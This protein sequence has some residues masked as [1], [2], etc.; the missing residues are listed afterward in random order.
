M[1][2]GNHD[3]YE[4]LVSLTGHDCALRCSSIAHS[5]KDSHCTLAGTTVTNDHA[6]DT[7]PRLLSLAAHELR[8]PLSVVAGY[9]HMLLGSKGQLLAPEHR[10]LVELA[11]G[12]CQKAL[13]ITH[14]LSDLARLEAGKAVL[15]PGHT[16][17][18]RL[19][20][21]AV[22]AARLRVTD[23][24]IAYDP[25]ATPLPIVADA[26][27]VRGALES[28]VVAVARETSE[29]GTL[30]VAAHLSDA[31]SA[32]VLRPT[33]TVTIGGASPTEADRTLPSDPEFDAYRGGLGLRLPIAVLVISGLGGDLRGHGPSTAPGV[34]VTLPAAA[35]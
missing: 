31:S 2:H 20:E 21:V 14:E 28:L 7:T 9:L 33:I 30:A 1:Q 5:F 13:E 16:D 18:G 23:V 6:H 3:R 27:R 11:N 15:N 12:S 25:P 17:V 26:E 22:S 4:R 29:H 19:L 8:G 10:R 32:T 34:T 24:T 35:S